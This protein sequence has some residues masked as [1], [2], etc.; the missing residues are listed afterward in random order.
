MAKKEQKQKQKQKQKQ[1]QVTKVSVKVGDTKPK[2]RPSSAPAK[3]AGGGGGGGSISVILQ[4]AGLSV[5]NPPTQQ[6]NEMVQAVEALRRQMALSGSLIPRQATNDLLNRVQASNPLTSSAGVTPMNTL[7][8]PE[9]LEEEQV[10]GAMNIDPYSSEN[11]SARVPIDQDFIRNAR[12]ASLGQRMPARATMEIGITEDVENIND[13]AAFSQQDRIGQRRLEKDYG[14]DG[15]S[16]FTTVPD[17]TAFSANAQRGSRMRRLPTEIVEEGEPFFITPPSAKK[18]AA[19]RAAREIASPG[20]FT[21]TTKP[22]GR[23]KKDT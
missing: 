18:I 11:F 21:P 16:A 5:P 12:L 22:R 8:R 20:V 4:G 15:S 17:I 6:Y 1:S 23:P 10:E 2:R 3:R 19:A 7:I 14:D 13:I 9:G